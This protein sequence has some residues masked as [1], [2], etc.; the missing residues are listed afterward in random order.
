MGTC[1]SEAVN[2]LISDHDSAVTNS[3]GGRMWTSG[4]AVYCDADFLVRISE[5]LKK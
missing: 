3:R 4:G 5:N 1:L 2:R